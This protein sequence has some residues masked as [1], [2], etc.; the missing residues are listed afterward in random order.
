MKLKLKLKLKYK[1]NWC[2]VWTCQRRP[3]SSRSARC[4]SLVSTSFRSPVKR[5]SDVLL[6]L[7][8]SRLANVFVVFPWTIC[9]NGGDR[10]RDR[11]ARTPTDS[12]LQRAANMS[13]MYHRFLVIFICIASPYNILSAPLCTSLSPKALLTTK[14]DKITWK[15][16]WPL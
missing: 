9:D 8:L 2:I 4:N 7:L 3:T 6:L 13:T 16:L 12:L 1:W 11:V 15:R 14:K 5:S 10:D